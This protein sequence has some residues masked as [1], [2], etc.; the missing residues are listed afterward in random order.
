MNEH[1]QQWPVSMKFAKSEYERG[2]RD[3]AAAER[4]R[5]KGWLL[6]WLEQRSGGIAI[7]E[8]IARY[9]AREVTAATRAPKRKR[10]TK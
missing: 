3:G 1:C 6:M 10:G 4:R 2:K 7:A 8:N 9:I 5:I